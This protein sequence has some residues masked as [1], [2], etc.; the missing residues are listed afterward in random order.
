MGVRVVAYQ[1]VIVEKQTVTRVEETNV[2]VD[3]FIELDPVLAE[4]SP[5]ASTILN[6]AVCDKV[7]PDANGW[8]KERDHW[9]SYIPSNNQMTLFKPEPGARLPTAR[10]SATT[11]L[12]WRCTRE[13]SGPLEVSVHPIQPL[14]RQTAE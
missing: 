14:Q 12:W 2:Q 1:P 13:A 7:S 5:W 4:D 10:R 9:I 8:F 11:K 6:I 3:R